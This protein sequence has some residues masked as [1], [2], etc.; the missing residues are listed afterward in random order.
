MNIIA[1]ALPPLPT[2]AVFRCAQEVDGV[3]WAAV[4]SCA[5]G[6]EGNLLHKLAGD[7]THALKPRVGHLINMLVLSHH[8]GMGG[9]T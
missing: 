8:Q 4:S 1:I 6:A 7:K 2:A 5:A 3:D 9:H